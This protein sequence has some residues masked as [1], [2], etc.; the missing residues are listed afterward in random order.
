MSTG[1]L[2]LVFFVTFFLMLFLGTPITY[3]LGG[4]GALAMA[5]SGLKMSLVIKSVLSGFGSF[6]LLAIFLF[7][8]MGV[9][10]QKTG[11]AGLLVDALKPSIG[12]KKGG[13][14]LIAVYASA[15]FGA[16]TGSAN[17]TCAT[18]SK[19][20]G[21]EMVDNGYPPDWTAATIA[22]CA[23]LGQLIPPSVTCIVL[24]VATGLSIGSLFMV[25]L[26][27]GLLTVVFL[28]FTIIW[29]ARRHGFGG[30]DKVYTKEEKRS[31][32]LRFLPLVSVPVV[33]IGGMY[34]GIFT[35]TEAGAIGSAFSFL[36]AIM[37]NRLNLKLLR[38]IFTDASKTAATVLLLCASSYVISYVMSMSGMTKFFIAVL[39]SICNV[40]PILGLLFL[41]L[42]LLIMGCFIDL[43]VLCIIL[44]PTAVAALAP[45]GINPYAICA[46]F[47]IGNLIGIITPPVGVALFISSS[48]LK[49][50]MEAIS[51]SVVPY[52]I[53]YIV[54]T[55][56]LIVFPDLSLALPRLLGM[57]I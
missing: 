9:I 42:V 13:L 53:V 17:A 33:V 29:M 16:L 47:L 23:P 35:A 40:S 2:A 7:T 8:L 5:A 54:M 41:L 3:A 1:L 12:K 4:A 32:F 11:L 55:V 57:D 15:I 39:T 31:A 27:I 25:D 19:M 6:T 24:G 20:L 37:Y 10:Y 48:S 38:D 49:V 50:K 30:S 22:A 34:G 21:P 36:L 26:S 51:K 56:L 44:A 46:V 28:T 14:A 43:I 52:I 18:F 45:F